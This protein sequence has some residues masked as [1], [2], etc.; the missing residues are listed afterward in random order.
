MQE[1]SWVFILAM[2]TFAIGAGF[3][4][5]IRCARTTGSDKTN[6]ATKRTVHAPRGYRQGTA[7]RKADQPVH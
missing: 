6:L 1:V 4:S 5:S 3:Y 7:S 2:A